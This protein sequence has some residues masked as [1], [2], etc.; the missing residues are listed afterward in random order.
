[1]ESVH[2]LRIVDQFLCG[3]KRLNEIAQKSELLNDQNE[4]LKDLEGQYRMIGDISVSLFSLA[5]FILSYYLYLHQLISFN[6]VLI[7]TIA[8]MSSF[9]P[10]LALSSLAHNLVITFASAIGFLICWMKCRKLLR[11]VM[12]IKVI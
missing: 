9:G 2:G 11:L 10:V 4:E 8:L 5:M 1:M 6:G 7:G 3:K 12:G